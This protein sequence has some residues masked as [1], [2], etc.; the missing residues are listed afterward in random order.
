VAVEAGVSLWAGVVP[1]SDAEI[2]V[3]QAR[4]P[5]AELANHLGIGAESMG[6]AIVATPVCGLAVATPAYARR[7]LA[8][9][10][11]LGRMLIDFD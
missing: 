9:L 2:S 1:S 7:A 5:L 3:R 4:K 10:A 11:E 6:T 8:V